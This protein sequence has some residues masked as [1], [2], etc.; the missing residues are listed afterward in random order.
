MKLMPAPLNE[1][2]VVITGASSGIGRATALEFGKQGA[3]VVLAAR[4]DEALNEVAALIEQS[5]G[6]ALVANTDV[7]DMEHMKQLAY[8]AATTFGKI[9]T[10][11]NN[12]GIMIYATVEETTASEIRRLM[13]VNYLGMVHGV[14]A[15]LPYMKTQ[16][17]GTIINVGS[18]ESERALPLQAA[19]AASKHAVKGFTEALRMELDYEDSGINVTLIMPSGMNTPL[20]NHAR[21]RLGRLPQPTKPIYEPEMVAHAIVDAAQN[22]TRQ[23]YVGGT[24]FLVAMLQRISPALLDKVMIAKGFLF[25][26]QTS[27]RPD[28]GVDNLNQPIPEGGRVHGDF[29]AESRPSLYTTLM[30]RTPR[31]LRRLAMLSGTA[32]VITRL[33]ARRLAR[34]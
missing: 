19:Y 16:G 29:T 4:N 26:M 23:I 2:V 10:W 7:S 3:A 5:G 33:V 22:P 13:E 11:V 1:Q 14:L 17:Y 9:D 25:K 6:R 31:W 24:G 34:T 32:F 18:V 30:H 8:T 28:D 27:D 20:F 15:V 21:S 12:A